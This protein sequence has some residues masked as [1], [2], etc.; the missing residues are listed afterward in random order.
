MNQFIGRKKEFETLRSIQ[1]FDHACLVVVKGRR[2]I[3]K[4]RLIQEFAKGSRFLSFTGVV[5][6]NGTTAQSQRDEFA[7][8]LAKNCNAQEKTYTSWFYALNELSSHLTNEQTIILFD[9]ISWMGSH[10]SGFVGQLKVWWDLELQEKMPNLTLIFCGSVS[11]WIEKNILRSTAFFGRVA[12][13]I[14]LEQLS[15]SECV[16]FLHAS[17]I[18]ASPYDTFKL[19]AVT[20]GV[21]SYLGRIDKDF[22]IENNI[23]KLCFE[24]DGFL[25][26]E[27]NDIF[28]D[29]FN[30]H[31]SAYKQVIHLLADGMKDLQGIQEALKPDKPASLEEVMQDL[32]TA[33]FV[34]GHYSWSFKTEKAN[35]R[36]LYRLSDN[37][38][39]FYVKYIEPN[40]PQI[41]LNDFGEKS[42]QNLPNWD[43]VMG[44]QVENLLLNNR[45]LLVKALDI[46]PADV[47]CHNPYRQ[48]PSG[49]KKGCQIDYLLQSNSQTLYV[50]EFKFKRQEIGP[51]IIASVQEKISRLDIPKG[52]GA[53][54]VLFHFGGVKDSVRGTGY[55]YKIIDVQDF[56]KTSR[57]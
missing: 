14:T 2:R 51:E 9:E 17:N 20:G 3:G 21:P 13:T 27:F 43:G 50:C 34:C 22:P 57:D 19:L 23:K 53:I 49:D 38:L 44:L 33:G 6:T 11:T 5:P 41:S 18:K 1:K 45:S 15:L 8:Q 16:E 24:P 4:S 28:H 48:R 54:P 30:G 12:Q 35:T 40:M 32:I 25:T 10:D 56:L 37:Y 55:F 39:R 29:L 26:K 31:S 7:K 47:V 42:L 52:F 36:Y 46:H